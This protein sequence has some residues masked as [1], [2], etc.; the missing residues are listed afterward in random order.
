MPFI[1]KVYERNEQCKKGYAEKISSNKETRQDGNVL[2]LSKIGVTC[3]L[4]Y[5]Q[6]I[7]RSLKQSN[8]HWINLRDTKWNQWECLL[9]GSNESNNIANRHNRNWM[10]LWFL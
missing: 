3:R 4:A 8:G 7:P 6:L 5:E 9:V 10:Y 1:K 2:W